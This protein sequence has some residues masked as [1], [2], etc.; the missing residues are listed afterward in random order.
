MQ[1]PTITL[2]QL[3]GGVWTDIE[4]FNGHDAQQRGQTALDRKILTRA[5]RDSWRI[6]NKDTGQVWRCSLMDDKHFENQRPAQQ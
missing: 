6:S 2:Q 5:D 4:S 1:F 3:V